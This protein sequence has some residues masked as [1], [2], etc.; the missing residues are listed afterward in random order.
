MVQTELSLDNEFGIR[1]TK[2][3]QCVCRLK[4]IEFLLGLASGFL[5]YSY[6]ALGYNDHDHLIVQT[7]ALPFYHTAVLDWCPP[8][9]LQK[10]V[11]LVHH[12]IK[13]DVS[14]VSAKFNHWKHAGDSGPPYCMDITQRWNVNLSGG[15]NYVGYIRG[16]GGVHHN[17]TRRNTCL[18]TVKGRRN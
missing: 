10:L 8:A 9:K 4:T 17:I 3:V 2:K 11:I 13:C 7:M 18:L 1:S 15:N 16:T 14:M 6:T 12:C 5:H